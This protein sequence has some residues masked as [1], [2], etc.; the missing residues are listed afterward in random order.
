MTRTLII[1]MRSGLMRDHEGQV[2]CP[3]KQIA[4]VAITNDMGYSLAC[5]FF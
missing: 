5:F 2:L 1:A 3:I 4:F